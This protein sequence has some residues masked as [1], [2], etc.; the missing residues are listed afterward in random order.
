MS[1]ITDEKTIPEDVLRAALDVSRTIYPEI[2]DDGRAYLP[3]DAVEV[4]AR[5]ILDEREKATLFVGELLEALRGFSVTDDNI[6][7]ATGEHLIVR[8][9]I[10]AITAAASAIAKAEGR[11]VG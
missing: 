3:N 11:L 5:A 8:L 10:K 1:K 4:I 6:V 7:G 9:P 2:D